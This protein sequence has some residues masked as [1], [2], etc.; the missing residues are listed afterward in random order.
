LLR[1]FSRIFVDVRPLLG[2]RGRNLEWIMAVKTIF[3]SVVAV[4]LA[5][6]AFA[7]YSPD[8]VAEFS[9]R[10]AALALDARARLPLPAQP[11][12]APAATQPAQ[13]PATP[14]Q[15]QTAERKDFPVLLE[16]LGQVAAYNT[17]TVKARI[18]GQIDKI[19]FKEGQIVHKGDL[20]AEIDPRPFQAA[21][22]QAQAKEEQDNATLA[23]AKRDLDRYSTL[24]KQSFASEQQLDTQKALVNSDTALIAADDAAIDSAKVQLGY[25]T[26]TAP[27]TGRVGYRLVDQG[28]M[29]AASQQT[30]IVVINQLQ[31]ISVTFTAPEEQV[32]EINALRKAGEAKVEVK[33][34]DGKPLSTGVLE[35][36]DNQIDTSTG[37]VKLKARFANEDEKLWPGLAVI[38]DLTL[39]VDKNAVVVPTAS[40]QHGSKGLY[41]YVIG[42]DNKAAPHPV[43]I[44]HQNSEEAAIASGLQGGEKIVTSGQSRLRPGSLVVVQAAEPRS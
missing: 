28:N 33:T 37:T 25:T 16:S 19:A 40:V 24:A 43:K 36:V 35:V 12:P 41:V 42:D 11:T 1:Y 14:V 7:I 6:A 8:Q 18:D 17:V 27:L 20:L 9:P 13:T 34:T 38:V 32:G 4:A 3:W 23:N 2:E 15:A 21:V 30:G 5:A 29:V 26:I 44:S 10:A 31:P 22:A 39:G